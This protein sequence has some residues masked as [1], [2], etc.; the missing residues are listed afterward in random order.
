VLFTPGDILTSHPVLRDFF[1]GF[2]YILGL[3]LL[4]SAKQEISDSPE[5]AVDL[6]SLGRGLHPLPNGYGRNP[7]LQAGVPTSTPP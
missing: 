7:G 4:S 1:L 3:L 5:G 6:T 2:S